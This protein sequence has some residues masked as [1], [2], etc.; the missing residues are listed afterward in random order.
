[1]F[2]FLGA[3]SAED[4]L[5]QFHIQNVAI[6]KDD[7]AEGLILGGGSHFVLNSQVSY[8]GV[9]FRSA[10]AEGVFFVVEKDKA[11][12]PGYVGKFGAE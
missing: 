3:H 1:M 2:G 6:K 9:D 4:G 5:I 7:G 12:H 11:A 10:H 8:E